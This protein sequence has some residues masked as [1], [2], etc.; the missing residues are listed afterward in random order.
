MARK[1]IEKKSP[2]LPLAEGKFD[3]NKS[4]LVFDFSNEGGELVRVYLPQPNSFK[5]SK[6]IN[7]MQYIYSLTKKN[8]TI[9]ENP[10]IMLADWEDFKRGCVSNTQDLIECEKK[11]MELQE[12]INLWLDDLISRGEFI[13][14]EGD[15]KGKTGALKDLITDDNIREMLE[16]RAVFQYALLRYLPLATGIIE[17]RESYTAL[18]FTDYHASFMRCIEGTDKKS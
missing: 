10:E 11:F 7:F 17:M 12:N 1:T 9:R 18:S 5:T 6:I 2:K 15:F 16:I 4:A 8:P 13:A 3:K 14:L